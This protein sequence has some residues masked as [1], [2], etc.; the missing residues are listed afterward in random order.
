M[1]QQIVP[2][3]PL[4]LA[5]FHNRNREGVPSPIG[6]DDFAE[7]LRDPTR[8]RQIP[9]GLVVPAGQDLATL[10]ACMQKVYD[11]AG[12][13]GPKIVVPPLPRITDKQIA[14]LTRFGMRLFYV[15]AIG[16]DAYPDTFVKPVWDKYLTGAQIERRKLPGKWIAVETIPKCNWTDPQGYAGGNDPV[17]AALGLTSRFGISWDNHHA[18]R[19]T[20]PRLAKLGNFP[21][22]GTRF[23]TAEEVNFVANMFNL[24]R[25]CH[26]MS[27]LP[28]L[29]LTDSWEWCG[30]A[31]GSGY[32]V[33]VGDRDDGGLAAVGRDWRDN[34]NGNIGFRVLVQ[35]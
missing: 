31:Y 28:N 19:G 32:R 10:P 9:S 15:P 2:Y 22:R 7:F 33:I 1:S 20:L 3:H 35:F 4:H 13:K 26:G 24:L 18:R 23:G 29:G 21:K 30:N 34:P 14:A 17:A 25:E 6:D 12:F 8:W 11:T 5:E 27:D 16:E